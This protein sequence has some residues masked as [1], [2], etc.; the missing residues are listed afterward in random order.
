MKKAKNIIAIIAVILAFSPPIFSQN[1]IQLIE[2][3]TDGNSESRTRQTIS[4]AS[5]FS[6]QDEINLATL[7]DGLHTFNARFKD[8]YGVWS[9]VETRFFVKQ[10]NALGQGKLKKITALEYWMN[11]NSSNR[12]QRILNGQT[13]FAWEE[14]IDVANISD[15]VNTFN[16]RFKDEYGVWS[17]VETRFFVKQTNALGQGKLKK[18]TALEYW[19]NGNS[20]NRTQRILN[21]QTT[22]AWEELIDVANIPDGVNTFN[23]RFKD[24][25]GV[26]SPVETRFFVKQSTALTEGNKNITNLEYWMDGNTANRVSKTITPNNPYHWEELIP[27]DELQNGLHTFNVRWKDEKG[28]WT[29][30]HTLFFVKDENQFTS[31]GENKIVGYR[32]WFSEEPDYFENIPVTA[33]ENVVAINDSVPLTYLPKGR[34]QIAYQLKDA[35]GVWSPVIADSIDKPDHALFSFVADKL[36][37]AKGETVKF[38]P[39]TKLFIDSIVWSFG[40][41]MTEINFE[42]EHKYDSIGK[43]DVMTTVWHRGTNEGIPYV[44]IK[45]ITVASTGLLAPEVYTLKMYPVPAKNVLTIESPSLPMNSIQLVALNGKVIKKVLPENPEKTAFSVENLQPGTYIVVVKTDKGWLTNKI[46][47]E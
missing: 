9:P 3:W 15:G 44:E 32:L 14:L 23:A 21:A 35:R 13:T 18:I 11:G 7:V 38:T 41:G 36:E 16:A 28:I 47:K 26:W 1:S 2:F 45:Y 39:S 24:E 37:I 22:F 25:Y 19:M 4:A 10:T 20:S 34:H 40:D 5:V 8:E 27:T 6:W 33:I 42:P 17:P 43:F 12:T 31:L 30:V 46:V 29:M